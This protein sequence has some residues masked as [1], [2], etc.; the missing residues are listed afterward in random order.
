MGAMLANPQLIVCKS[1]ART[2]ATVAES[3]L[4]SDTSTTG[5]QSC[6]TCEQFRPLFDAMQT[7]DEECLS[8]GERRDNYRPKQDAFA[9]VKKTH[10]Q[11]GNFL[12]SVEGTVE[13]P[14][15]APSYTHAESEEDRSQGKKRPRS[16]SSVS[17]AFSPTLPS[18]VRN[19]DE[20]KRLRFSDSV[21]SREHYRPSQHYSRSD[22]AYE[23]GRYAPPE[24]S[25][26][27][28]TSGSVKTFF[29]FTGMKKVGKE[30]VDL[31]KEDEE[32]ER[33]DSKENA[34]NNNDTPIAE[35][36]TVGTNM[37]ASSSNTVSNLQ[38]THT[39]SALIQDIA[40]TEKHNTRSVIG[41]ENKETLSSYA[42]VKE[43]I[44]GE[45]AAAHLATINREF[46]R[47]TYMV[48]DR[49]YSFD[50]DMTAEHHFPDSSQS[51]ADKNDQQQA[52]EKQH[53]NSQTNLE[54]KEE[55]GESL[56]DNAEFSP[57]SKCASLSI[58]I[59]DGEGQGTES[60][61]QSHQPSVDGHEPG[62]R[63]RGATPSQRRPPT[64]H[65][66]HY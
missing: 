29:K 3:G 64:V 7:A 27:L 4:V 39:L 56:K 28:D 66:P 31:W 60:L 45:V 32:D 10:M 58:Q 34:A 42:Q 13:G 15:I 61:G 52:S 47:G 1:C 14:Q 22:D 9:N 18:H 46:T 54:R 6:D 37:S 35:V 49:Q 43:H 48:Q 25:E 57:N 20:H 11:F 44:M 51:S 33:N 8:F 19:I 50:A 63:P 62:S 21:E 55:Q 38:P 17:E 36:E 12:I 40:L 26:H 41:G 53:G 59:T 16:T 24:G 30:W 5:E 2:L 65:A 23:R